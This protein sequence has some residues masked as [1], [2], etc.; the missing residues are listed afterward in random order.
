M[1]ER[2]GR[3]YHARCRP[4]ERGLPPRHPW[5]KLLPLPAPR[6][7][8]AYPA[9]RPSCG[10]RSAGTARWQDMGSPPKPQPRRSDARPSHPVPLARRRTPAR[11]LDVASGCT[12]V[13]TPVFDT[14]WRFAARRQEIFMQRV[15]GAPPP[16]TAD[17]ILAAH[18]FTNVYRAA[19]RVS[20]FLIKSVIYAGSPIG[21]EVVFRVLLFRFFNRISTWRYLVDTLGVPT[22]QHFNARR[23]ARALDSAFAQPQ[24]LY[25]AA[26]I[27]P[28]PDFGHPRK[29][30]NHLSLLEH[31]LRDGAS[32]RI[33]RA[34]S[35]ANVFAILREYSSLGNFLAYQLAIDLNYSELID[36]P[37][38]TFVV[39][40]PGAR[41]GISKCFS[42]AGGL[43]DADVIHVV[44]ESATAQFA[45]LGLTFHTLW[46]RPLQPIDCQNLFC[47]VDKY[48][49][50]A[51][52]DITG[53]SG[54]VRIKQRF[55]PDPAPLP[56]W[57][58]PKWGLS[59]STGSHSL[60]GTTACGSHDGTGVS[61]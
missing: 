20:Q 25:S 8:L 40:G 12:L 61:K 43:S 49:R 60:P 30:R 17:P 4:T 57:Y 24:A 2:A 7:R 14:Y 15:A 33:A 1:D 11:H 9:A 23:Y 45:R 6:A 36:F 39:A 29:H 5:T 37:E 59:P 47:E 32:Q 13:A 54:R 35:L 50:V 58:P 53:H 42:A 52:P 3:F 56:Q 26:Y 48:S 22:W 28:S 19:D 16:W 46:G 44:A 31:I 55:A 51:H 38:S 18:R 34:P 41:S 10:T 27:I 21:E